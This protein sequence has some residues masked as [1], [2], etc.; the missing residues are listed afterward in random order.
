MAD[1]S[2]ATPRVLP[3][4]HPDEWSQRLA[5]LL[6]AIP[7]EDQDAKPLLQL[8]K[9]AGVPDHEALGFGRAVAA[10]LILFGSISEVGS[11]ETDMF[12]KAATRHS[13][14]FNRSLAAYIREGRS[15]L[16]DWARHAN[17]DGSIHPA[18]ILK[19]PQFLTH[20]ERERNLSSK[21]SEIVPLRETHVSQLVIKAK[22]RGLGTCYLMQYDPAARMYQ[23]VGG[24]RRDGDSDSGVT[25]QREALEELPANNFDFRRRDHLKFL[26]NVDTVL[27]SRTLGVNTL[28]HFSFYLA[29]LGMRRLNINLAIDKWIGEKEVEAGQTRDGVVIATEWLGD[30][31]NRIPGG[32]SA[33]PHSIDSTQT[34]ALRQIIRRRRWEIAGLTIG[35][36]GLIAAI[37]M[38]FI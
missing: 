13:M 9:E 23:L 19:G 21:D 8:C 36:L 26:A 11:L 32:I 15:V 31:Q 16:F 17:P 3:R 24:H 38:P 25:M 35:I 27:V 18:D 4:G 30:L 12:I 14:Y 22:V 5:A 7:R 1:D 10:S 33:L 2:A 28:Y 29:K 20:L 34:T 6:E 37:S